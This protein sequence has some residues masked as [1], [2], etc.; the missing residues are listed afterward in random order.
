MRV[1]FLYISLFSIALA[2]TACSPSRSAGGTTNPD[3]QDVDDPDDPDDPDNTDPT[4]CTLPG[5][6]CEAPLAC[7]STAEG[8]ECLMPVADGA[9]E[10]E[11][12]TAPTDC[13]PGL[14]CV[15]G[16]CSRS[17]TTDGENSCTS[18]ICIIENNDVGGCIT[19][20]VADEPRCAENY[21]CSSYGAFEICLPDPNPGKGE[22]EFC[23][24]YNECNDS[25]ACIGSP[26]ARCFTPCDVNKPCDNGVCLESTT[27]GASYCSTS[28]EVRLDD[29]GDELG[30]YDSILGPACLPPTPDA[31]GKDSAC[32]FDAECLPGHLCIEEYCQIVCD[33]DS[34]TDSCIDGKCIAWDDNRYGHYGI[35]FD[36]CNPTD[37][38]PCLYDFGCYVYGDRP[39]CMPS[40]NQIELDQDCNYVNSCEPGLQCFWGVCRATCTST[41][42]TLSCEQGEGCRELIT[43]IGACINNCDLLDITTCESGEG[44]FSSSTAGYICLPA[45]D[46]SEGQSCDYSNDC[47]AGLVCT[48][49]VGQPYACYPACD[50]G[51][52]ITCDTG[53]CVGLDGFEPWGACLP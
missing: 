47:E 45:G 13:L 26:T 42:A 36:E 31:G 29:C 44:C 19:E 46:K 16:V 10:G 23:A 28:C 38:T 35:C 41:S 48:A 2:A 20:C 6:E 39:I 4:V 33:P 18:G 7:Y 52:S 24:F 50:L 15:S 17:C 34:A 27:A 21:L 14:Q 11:S 32:T 22:F 49:K 40:Y 3:G 30:C 43:G 9:L 53:T 5:L 37:E 51:G 25:L 8:L 1:A 12:C